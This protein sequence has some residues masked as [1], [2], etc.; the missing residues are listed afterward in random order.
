M[1]RAKASEAGT[2]AEMLHNVPLEGFGVA[3]NKPTSDNARK[4]AVKNAYDEASRRLV[5]QQAF[6]KKMEPPALNAVVSL[7]SY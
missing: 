5:P 6:Q 7:G 4:D 2:A 3:A 1:F